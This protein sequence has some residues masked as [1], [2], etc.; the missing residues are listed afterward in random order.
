M[1][2]LLIIL[3]A[4]LG[5]YYLWDYL[6]Q[7]IHGDEARAGLWVEVKPPAGISIVLDGRRV[8]RRSP[9][10]S[11]KLQPGQHDLLVRAK[12]HHPFNQPLHLVNDEMRRIN[13]VLRRKQRSFQEPRLVPPPKPKLLP[14]PEASPV[15]GPPLPPG[16]E[17]IGLVMVASPEAEMR[18]DGVRTDGH[19][20]LVRSR[21]R[22]RAG[23]IE[24]KYRVGGKDL[25]YITLPVDEAKWI[26]DEVPIRAGVTFRLSRG[27]VKLERLKGE[28]RSTLLLRR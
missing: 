28:E 15:L 22:L 5:A 21:G 11:R 6:R 10:V 26:K 19:I 27:V 4:L 24:V 20:R 12:G 13:V 23:S 14:P 1:I 7:L 17:R 16:V 2:I 25:L 3:L 8:A 9:F 18:F